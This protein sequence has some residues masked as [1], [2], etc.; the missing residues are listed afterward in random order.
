MPRAILVAVLLGLCGCD[1]GFEQ[2]QAECTWKVAQTFPKADQGDTGYLI[3]TC[4]K[5]K[6]Y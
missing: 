6:G 1:N 3:A 2:A 4:M 5:A